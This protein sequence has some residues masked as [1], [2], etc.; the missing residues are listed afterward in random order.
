MLLSNFGLVGVRA[1]NNGRELVRHVSPLLSTLGSNLATRLTARLLIH[2]SIFSD[3]DGACLQHSQL[4]YE[5]MLARD[6]RL[7]VRQFVLHHTRR[8]N[9]GFVHM[10][11][12]RRIRAPTE[13]SHELKLQLPSFWTNPPK[14]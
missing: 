8:R 10:P 7:W 4:R 1:G 3:D 5:K 11:A 9:A 13:M 14:P 6:R 12:S 2:V